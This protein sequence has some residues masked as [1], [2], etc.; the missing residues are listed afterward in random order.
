MKYFTIFFLL[1]ISVYADE[2]PRV[3]LHTNYGIIV[4]E[5]N[6]NK[7]PKTVENF[8]KYANS[9]FYDDT[10][11]HRVIKNYVIQGGGYTI[12]YEKKIPL[13]EPVINES[14]N[15]LENLYG[16]IAMARSYRDP[17]SA[18]FQFFI[19]VKD[20][21]SLNYNDIMEEMGYTVFG[22]VIEGMDIVDKIQSLKTGAK[23]PL[24]KHVPQMKAIIE[25]VVVK[26]INSAIE[27]PDNNGEEKLSETIDTMDDTQTD[28]EN[29]ITGENFIEPTIIIPAIPPP[30][31]ATLNTHFPLLEFAAEK[32]PIDI[33]ML[34][35]VRE[36]LLKNS[37]TV[38]I[39]A[40]DTPSQPDIP[41]SLPE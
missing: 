5:L 39:P 38:S 16:T 9:N 14:D 15:G 30:K 18:T 19:N 13:Y 34:P 25:L 36:K 35:V 33:K 7:A 28:T 4:L 20:N 3:N 12:N 26:N 21:L 22:K 41:D 11:F 31:L 10:I 17:D 27:L 29:I 8:L 24:K 2:P 6:P 40:P 37:K 23:G 32:I 1:T